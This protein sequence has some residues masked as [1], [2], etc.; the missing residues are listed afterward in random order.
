LTQRRQA[1][2]SDLHSQTRLEDEGSELEKARRRLKRQYEEVIVSERRRE[3]LK[4]R[5]QKPE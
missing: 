5:K 1:K 4:R 3:E 2:D